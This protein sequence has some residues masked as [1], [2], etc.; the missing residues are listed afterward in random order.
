MTAFSP[1][2]KRPLMFFRRSSEK[3]CQDPPPTDLS[4]S[5]LTDSFRSG[6]GVPMPTLPLLSILIRS[7]NP[8]PIARVVKKRFPPPVTEEL[9]FTAPICACPAGHEFPNEMPHR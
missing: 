3:N 9:I 6:V 5:P 2:L 1:L 8:P 4:A 7:E